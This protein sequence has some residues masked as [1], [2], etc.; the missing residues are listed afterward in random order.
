MGMV[1]LEREKR[2][3]EVFVGVVMGIGRNGEKKENGSG[4]GMEIQNRMDS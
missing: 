2:V 4:N 1:D 3:R